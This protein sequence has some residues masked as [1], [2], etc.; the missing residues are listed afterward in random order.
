MAVWRRKALALFPELRAHLLRSD[1][2]V[3]L[4]FFELLPMV[5]QAHAADD[6]E[7]LRGLYGFAEWCSEQTA[8]E[9][10]NAA[11]VAFYEHLFDSDIWNLR[12]QIVPWLSPHVVE[13]TWPLLEFRLSDGRLSEVKRLLEER[14]ETRYLEARQTAAAC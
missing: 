9:L 13:V 12:E 10:W 11:G 1:F 5:R 8:K 7:R 3:M 6:V 2:G 4:L 14:T